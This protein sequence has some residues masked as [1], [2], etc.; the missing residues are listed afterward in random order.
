MLKKWATID[1]KFLG[2]HKVFDLY[3]KIRTN[4]NT[5]KS[6]SFTS[7]EAPNW[8]NVVAITEEN[9]LILVEQ[10]RHGIDDFSLELPAGVIEKN[11][12]PDCAAKRECTEETGYCG[13]DNVLLLGEVRP[14]PAFLN[15]FCY[16]YLWL[17]CRLLND[18][19]LDENEDIKVV[20]CPMNEVK[21]LIT[22]RKLTHT[23]TLSALLLYSLKFNISLI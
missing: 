23:L 7:L 13:G 19:K 2:N 18:Q 11:E 1:S 16:H 8:V 22:G 14:N 20:L 9:E 10:Y 3:H 12:E 15:N 6:Y 21:K 17:N 5:L 4:P